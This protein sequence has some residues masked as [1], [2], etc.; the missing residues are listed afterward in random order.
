MKALLSKT[1]TIAAACAV[2]SLAIASAAHAGDVATSMRIEARAPLR[3]TLMPTV[4]V[5]ADAAT[6][7]ARMRVADVA[8]IE[9]TLMPT[10]YVTADVPRERNAALLPVVRVIADREAVES[11]ADEEAGESRIAES[12]VAY[13]PR[14]R[15]HVVPR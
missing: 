1:R 11:F 3:V 12:S 5:D 13:E 15:R 7:E 10:V 4:S 9:A 2:A 6:S 8:P 14:A